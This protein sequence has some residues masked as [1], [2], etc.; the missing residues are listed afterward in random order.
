MEGSNSLA[1]KPLRNST[2]KA[3]ANQHKQT[4]GALRAKAFEEIIKADFV[5][6]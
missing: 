6:L 5:E 4:V 2:C 1:G 3:L